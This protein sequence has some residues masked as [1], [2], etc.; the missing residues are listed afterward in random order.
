MSR[1]ANQASLEF[2]RF[3]ATAS[4]VAL[5]F[6]EGCLSKG[7]Q[8]AHGTPGISLLL[9]IIRNPKRERGRACLFLADALGYD[10]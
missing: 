8:T 6:S 3:A 4:G 2:N 7:G 10:A 1:S 9:Q 5:Q